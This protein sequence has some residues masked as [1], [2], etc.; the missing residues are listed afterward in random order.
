MNFKQH[1]TMLVL[2]VLTLLSG[3]SYAAVLLPA[4]DIQQMA[5]DAGVTLSSF[6]F[7]IDATAFTIDT[8]GDPIDIPDEAFILTSTG[9]IDG[10]SGFFSG[11]FT[12][13]SLLSG[14][15]I[16]LA[17]K[18]PGNSGSFAGV[19]AFTGGSL[20]GGLSGGRLEGDFTGS[21][22]ALTKLGPVTA[23]PVPSAI[24]LFASGL[25]SLF[26]IKRSKV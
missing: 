6:I 17:V 16:D 15:F 26:G 12:V 19:V 20:M 21:G 3:G 22:L 9:F 10:G 8:G 4:I 13:G 5:G 1:V 25:I 18:V 14:D 23:I 2:P 7:N 11:V 24:W